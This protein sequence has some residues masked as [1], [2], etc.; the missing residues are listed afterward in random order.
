MNITCWS[1]SER[2]FLLTSFA[3]REIVIT[4][5]NRLKYFIFN[6]YLSLLCQREGQVERKVFVFIFHLL[7]GLAARVWRVR[8]GSIRGGPSIQTSLRLLSC[9]PSASSCVSVS[10]LPPPAASCVCVVLPSSRPLLSVIPRSFLLLRRF[11]P[12]YVFFLLPVLVSI[13]DY[14][15]REFSDGSRKCYHP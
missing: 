1:L 10:S 14:Y 5:S 6:L 15:W 3:L 9:A 13:A 2:A 7:S 12:Y 4:I 11:C 8:N